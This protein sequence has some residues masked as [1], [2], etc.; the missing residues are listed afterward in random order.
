MGTLGEEML[1]SPVNALERHLI[2]QANSFEADSSR[3]LREI[4][5]ERLRDAIR[6][7]DLRPGEH[8]SEVRLSRILGISRTPVREAVQQLA[9][10]GLIEIIPGRAIIVPHLTVKEVRDL[11]QMRSLLEP[12]VAR[13][14]AQSA[15][16]QQ[17]DVLLTA[18]KRMRKAAENEDRLAWSKADE[19][20][21]DTLTLACPNAVLGKTAHQLFGRLHHLATGGRTSHARL[22]ACTEEHLKVVDAVAAADG[23]AAAAAMA[24]HMTEMQKNLMQELGW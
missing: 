2:K 1:Q 13:L 24:F 6:C 12:E 18:C 7:A 5:Y 11:V 17:V 23:A 22:L 8:L 3:L 9:Q 10:E 16:R 19:K 14:A 4:A 15:T 20:F 21:H